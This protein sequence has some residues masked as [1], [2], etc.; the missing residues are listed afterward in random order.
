M[1]DEHLPLIFHP[2]EVQPAPSRLYFFDANVWLQLLRPYK[3]RPD[4][5]PYVK[6]WRQL[7]GAGM[8]C[9]VANAVLVSEVFNRYL[10]LRFDVWKTLPATITALQQTGRWSSGDKIDYKTHFRPSQTYKDYLELLLADWNDIAYLVT[11]LPTEVESSIVP[12]MLRSY[13]KRA[14]FNDRY[15]IEFCKAHKLWLV[16]HDGDFYTGGLTVV[17][18]NRD[19]LGK[20]AEMKK[21]KKR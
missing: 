8:P 3:V 4:M 18:A 21:N 6:L 9:I 5:S 2:D 14:D 11:Y 13:S 10:R 16:S 12:E 7:K 19:I 17:T 20:Y 15:Y 1:S